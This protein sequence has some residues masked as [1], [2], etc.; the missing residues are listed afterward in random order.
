LTDRG[1]AKRYA[2]ALFDVVSKSGET[3]RA[4]RDLT[5]VMEL[6]ASSDVLRQVLT[7]PAVSPQ[8]KHAVLA[9]VLQA[10][11]GLGPEVTRLLGMLAD[12]DRLS[13]VAGVADAF[14][15]RLQESDRVIPAEVVTAIELTEQQ[16]HGLRAAIGKASGGDVT[17]TAQV[18]PAIVG[19]IIARVGGMVFDGSVT[20]QL[21][22]MKQRL[23]DTA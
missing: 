12:R 8:K 7:A 18:D 3:A 22:K 11:G 10:A 1:A 20:R 5:S 6:L 15:Q 19:G 13:I 9:N 14:R 21:E 17:L 16:R 23:T 2:N 4:S